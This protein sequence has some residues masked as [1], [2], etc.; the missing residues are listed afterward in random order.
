MSWVI[1]KLSFYWLSEWL[2]LTDE[3]FNRIYVLTWVIYFFNFV[4]RIWKEISDCSLARRCSGINNLNRQSATRYLDCVMSVSHAW[5]ASRRMSQKKPEA[6]R[7]VSEGMWQYCVFCFYCI[8][9][10]F[11]IV[12]LI[13]TDLLDS[14]GGSGGF[15]ELDK[16]FYDRC[17]GGRTVIVWRARCTEK[18]TTRQ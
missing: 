5:R 18:T 10:I 13:K 17:F 1:K 11:F 3:S 9:F 7:N 2:S 4:K 14:N 6:Y 12:P 8:I 15:D 16:I